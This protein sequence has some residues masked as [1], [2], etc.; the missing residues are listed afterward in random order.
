MVSTLYINQWPP[1]KEV[2][3]LQPSLFTN[4][5]TFSVRL[6]LNKDLKWTMNTETVWTFLFI[7]VINWPSGPPLLSLPLQQWHL[8]S[9]IFSSP[10]HFYAVNT[11]RAIERCCVAHNRLSRTMGQTGACLFTCEEDSVILPN[12]KVSLHPFIFL[13]TT[14]NA[15]TLL[16]LLLDGWI[17]CL[18]LAFSAKY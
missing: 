6:S 1:N 15:L 10:P 18:H 2:A 16:L 14:C 8:Q 3:T 4:Y 13:I 17:L 9:G 12:C 7:F 11:I 5:V